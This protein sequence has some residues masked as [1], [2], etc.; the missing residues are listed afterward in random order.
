MGTTQRPPSSSALFPYLLGLVPP[1]GPYS[2]LSSSAISSGGCQRLRTWYLE[3][4]LVHTQLCGVS[5]FTQPDAQPGLHGKHLTVFLCMP[6]QSTGTL[7][8][9]GFF[10]FPIFPHTH[11]PTDVSLESSPKT[12]SQYTL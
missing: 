12:D 5:S 7:A 3:L 9:C 6:T 11:G 10:P 8:R 2:V 4:S 1:Q